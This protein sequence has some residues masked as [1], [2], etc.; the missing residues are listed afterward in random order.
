MQLPLPRI[1]QICA[2]HSIYFYHQ[3]DPRGCAL[4]VSS[5]PLTDSNYNHGVAICA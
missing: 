5:E 2:D 1:A 3:T 4:Y